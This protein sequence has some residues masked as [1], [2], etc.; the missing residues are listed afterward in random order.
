MSVFGGITALTILAAGCLLIS[1]SKLSSA[2]CVRTLRPTEV[3]SCSPCPPALQRLWRGYRYVS[4]VST[5]M[6]QGPMSSPLPSRWLSSDRTMFFSESA[7][8]CM[9]MY[10]GMKETQKISRRILFPRCRVVF[11]PVCV[12]SGAKLS[13]PMPG[14]KVLLTL[15]RRI[16]SPSAEKSASR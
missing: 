11:L 7:T 9:L 12:R 10:H 15:L 1:R 3:L 14:R 2:M 6:R 16:W 13:P 5:R 4:R 8:A